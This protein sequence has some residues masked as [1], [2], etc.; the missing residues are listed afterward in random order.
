MWVLSKSGYLKLYGMGTLLLG[1]VGLGSTEV[2]V[3]GLGLMD[4]RQ[5]LLPLCLRQM[6]HLL[7]C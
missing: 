4:L 7:L 3:A 1:A 2:F 5:I 6:E